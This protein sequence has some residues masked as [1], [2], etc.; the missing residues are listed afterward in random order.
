MDTA[1]DKDDQLLGSK[2]NGVDKKLD[3]KSEIVTEDL[4]VETLAGV[5]S[6]K[7]TD[8]EGINS[9]DSSRSVGLIVTDGTFS[10][11]V[12]ADSWRTVVIPEGFALTPDVKVKIS[13]IGK[14]N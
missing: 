6:S 9:D 12:K 5:L 10:L 14:E 8:S 1:D 7:S 4:S 2:R 11:V 13:V 3:E